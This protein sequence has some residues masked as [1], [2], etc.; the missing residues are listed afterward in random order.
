MQKYTEKESAPNLFSAKKI[1]ERFILLFLPRKNKH[2]LQADYKKHVLHFKAPAGTSRGVLR[3]KT[4]YYLVVWDSDAPHIKGIGECSTIKG[5]SIDPWD[6]YE[7]TLDTVC[8]N[9]VYYD[10]LLQHQLDDYPSIKFGLETAMLDLQKGGNRILFPSQF[11]NGA[12]GIPINGLIWMGDK[13]TM[14][15]RIRQKID[16]G[17]RCIKLKIGAIDFEDEMEL[18]K[19]IRKEF[20]AT[21]LELRVDA[22]GAFTPAEA[23][24]KLHRLAALQI[25]SIEQPIGQ[26]QWEDMAELCAGT[27]VPIALDEELIG[28]KSQEE[29]DRMLDVIKPQ[30]IILKPSLIGGFGMSKRFI[31]AAE[32]RNIGW[33]LTSALEGNIGLNA[34]AQWIFPWENPLPQG[35]GTGQLFTDNIPSPLTVK[36]AR[37]WYD[38]AK[39][40]DTSFITNGK[41][42]NL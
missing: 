7:Q 34:L 21:E 33:W 28:K 14:K 22:N 15:A 27:P 41:N 6:S 20:A 8:R 9:I 25:H 37:L 18:L 12:Q 23:K 1:Q 5:L 32:Q 29:I 11:S 30:Y 19:T 24:E 31:A 13:N 38:P 4:S 2:M 3:K 35:L 39:K 10:N 42:D 26:N 16:E 40:W 36:N 17:F